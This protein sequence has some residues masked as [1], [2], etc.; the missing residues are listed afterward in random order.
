MCKKVLDR[1][2]VP[3][4][5]EYLTERHSELPF[6]VIIDAYGVQELYMNCARFLKPDGLFVTVGIAFSDYTYASLFVAVKDMLRNIIFSAWGGHDWRRY[7]QVSATC[8]LEGL[9]R[10]KAMCEDLDL[11]VPIDSSWDFDDALKVR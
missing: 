10:L 4:V 8:S 9:Q 11:R 1:K 6:D 3:S 7:V 2:S 5:S